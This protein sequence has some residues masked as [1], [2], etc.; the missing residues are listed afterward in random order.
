MG[1]RSKHRHHRIE[2]TPLRIAAGDHRAIAVRVDDF[3]RPNG[4]VRFGYAAKGVSHLEIPSGSHRTYRRYLGESVASRP[5]SFPEQLDDPA[6]ALWSVGPR[7]GMAVDSTGFLDQELLRWA[8][9]PNV[10][11]D[12]TSNLIFESEGSKQGSNV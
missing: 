11:S 6:W 8:S 9:L 7:S 4:S 5:L 1:D 3:P 12:P 2:G 10:P